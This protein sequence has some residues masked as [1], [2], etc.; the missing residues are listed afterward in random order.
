LHRYREIVAREFV[1]QK[2]I[3]IYL[4]PE[5]DEPSDENYLSFSYAQ[6]AELVDT[7][8][9]AYKS[10]LKPDVFTLMTHYPKMLRRHIVS[11]SEIAELC[12]KIYY[13]HQKALDLIFEHRPDLQSKLAESLKE[14]ILKAKLSE[15]MLAQPE[16]FRKRHIYFA[17]PQRNVLTTQLKSYGWHVDKLSLYFDFHNTSDQLSLKLVVG[18]T[19]PPQP[20]IQETIHQLALSHPKI[21]RGANRRL[22]RWAVIYK[23]QFL[24]PTDYEDADIEGLAKKV[25]FEW[26]KFL[27]EDLPAIR[28]AL[29][30]IQWPQLI[31]NNVEH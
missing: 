13:K 14:I 25:E 8:C 5:G 9:Q 15:G 20:V 7:V 27:T 16:D 21:F 4:T 6:M 30:E 28:G 10:T 31:P 29:A 22:S 23:K 3:F 12:R 2:N 24:S 18:P 19:T 26:N 11:D 1:G 17:D